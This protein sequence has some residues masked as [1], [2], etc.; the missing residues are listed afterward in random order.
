LLCSC[1]NGKELFYYYSDWQFSGKE[2]AVLRKAH[3]LKK[4]EVSHYRDTVFPNSAICQVINLERLKVETMQDKKRYQPSAAIMHIDVDKLRALTNLK[5]LDLFGFRLAEFPYELAKLESLEYLSVAM[6]GFSDFPSDL[7]AFG[8]L[9][10]LDLSMNNYDS[11]PANIIFPKSLRNLAITNCKLK[12]IPKN[13]FQNSNLEIIVINNREGYHRD[14]NSNEIT[15]KIH[16][17]LLQSLLSSRS[18]K[19]VHIQVYSCDEK[20]KILASIDKKNH[21]R[22]KLAITNGQC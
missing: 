5:S 13:A 18:I 11:L 17:E 16:I 8:N 14:L 1:N 12:Y 22:I 10:S 19:K 4:L 3:K 15:V 7:S 20:K 9:E 2:K 6:S 21:S